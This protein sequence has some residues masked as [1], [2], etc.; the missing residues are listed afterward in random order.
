MLNREE[1]IKRITRLLN[2]FKNY[3]ISIN[4][5]KLY[6]DNKKAEDFFKDLLKFY[7]EDFTNLRNANEDNPNAESIDLIDE[8]KQLA[9]Q[10]TSRTDAKKIKDTI[11]GFY[12]HYPNLKRIIILLIGR[13]KPKFRVDFTENGKYHFNPETDIIDIQDIINKFNTY[14]A[15]KLKRI[16]QF[17]E[18]ELGYNPLTLTNQEANR[19]ILAEIF[20]YL[21]RSQIDVKNS[22]QDDKKDLTHI[23]KK[24]PLNF[25]KTDEGI[26]NTLFFDYFKYEPLIREFIDAEDNPFRI[27]GLKNKIQTEYC[28]IQNLN[29]PNEKINNPYIFDEIA[30]ILTPNI[31]AEYLFNA[32][33]IVLYFFERCDIGEKTDSEP[34]NNQ[35]SLFD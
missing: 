16:L 28:K 5:L 25:N 30:K 11:K 13:E 35:P 6:D 17:L 22:I 10:V 19:D 18:S 12:E 29:S 23:K 4:K 9:V 21:Y 2:D 24:I 34:K 8:E 15:N 33:L 3:V 31:K 27:D 1:Y 20:D 14:D 26:I 32:K 7:D